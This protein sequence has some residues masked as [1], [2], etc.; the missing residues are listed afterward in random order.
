MPAAL[1]PRPKRLTPLP[2]LGLRHRHIYILMILFAVALRWAYFGDPA[3]DYDEQIYR[4]IGEQMLDGRL[5]YVDIWD[6]KPIGL[7]LIY[8]AASLAGA[9][10]VLAYQLLACAAA[11]LGGILLFHLARHFIDVLG[12]CVCGI[13]YILFLSAFGV[14]VGQSEVYYIPLLI[15]M[16]LLTVRT[17][18]SNDLHAVRRASTW[19]I[20]LGGLALQIKYTVLP[21]CVFFGLCALW[22]QWRLGSSL[23]ALARQALLYAAIGLTPTVIVLG[24]YWYLSHLDAFLFANFTSIFFR[25][26]LSGAMKDEY[27]IR[28]A[29]MAFPLAFCALFGV[30]QW[31]MEKM[32]ARSSYLIMLGWLASSI[33]G[34]LM[35]GNI[36]IHYFAPVIPA[37]LAVA[38]PTMGMSRVGAVLT[39]ITFLIGLA[40]FDPISGYYIS[41]RNRIGFQQAASAAAPYVGKNSDCLYVFDGPTSLYEATRSCLPTIYVYPDHLSNAMEEHAI[42]VNTVAEVSRILR[43]QPSVI[44]TASRPIV[45]HYNAAT[46]Q[47][48][49]QATSRNYVRI[50]AFQYYPR[51][52]YVNVRR[53][54]LEQYRSREKPVSHL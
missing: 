41:Q 18:E 52:L 37:I 42:G 50:G 49:N 19:A 6:R 2:A 28:I 11:A 8:A 46:A 44:I 31:M 38:A 5:P 45:P 43:N 30:A 12:A 4:L 21:Q 9:G 51:L 33:A 48:I 36:Y 35:I 25:G 26:H 47:L 54:L 22:R 32:A 7:F 39:S 14:H 3:P 27:R 53:D 15:A 20:V 13:L 23:S 16:A 40:L 24:L 17:A 29:F 10:S 1:A 34:F